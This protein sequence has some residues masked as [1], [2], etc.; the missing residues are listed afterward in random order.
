MLAHKIKLNPNNI[1]RTY[2]QKAS[3]VAR[4][5]W[6]WGLARWNELYKIGEKPSGMSLKKEFNSL[7]K[8][9]FTF[10][11]EVTKYASQQ[12]FLQLKSAFKSFF[13][14]E[15]GKPRFKK[16]NRSK[17][18]FYIGGDQI[19]VDGKK[20]KIPNLGWV[21]MSENIRFGGKILN[22]TIS[23]IAHK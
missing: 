2:F 10:T 15:R 20:V 13:K 11:Y 22:A 14:K 19:K 21:K 18:S 12:P 7:K 5:S 17:D 8:S 4:F 3:G 23:K 16:K 1:Q 6:N 9:Q